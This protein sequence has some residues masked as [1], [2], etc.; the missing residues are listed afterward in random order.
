VN[1]LVVWKNIGPIVS[2]GQVELYLVSPADTG[3]GEKPQ[4][5]RR[6]MIYSEGHRR[7]L[8]YLGSA[9]DIRRFTETNDAMKKSYLTKSG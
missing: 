2:D 5:H 9:G 1:V 4:R 8:G 6:R 7:K 3:I